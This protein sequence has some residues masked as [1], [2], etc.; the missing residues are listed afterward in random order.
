AQE[1]KAAGRRFAIIV[2]CRDRGCAFG[3]FSL[4]LPDG[5][6]DRRVGAS[7]SYLWN[8]DCADC[9]YGA[10][11]FCG[12][13]IKTEAEIERNT[14]IHLFASAQNSPSCRIGRSLAKSGQ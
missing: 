5:F 9:R 6:R 11:S 13:E 1:S 4:P 14:Q 7:T 2:T 12:D 10:N 3:P 8:L